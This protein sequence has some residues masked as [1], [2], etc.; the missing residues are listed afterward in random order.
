MS[1][2]IKLVVG[3]E[4]HMPGDLCMKHSRNEAHTGD[5]ACVVEV[6]QGRLGRD[7]SGFFESV[8]G[9]V[10]GEGDFNR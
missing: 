1:V 4:I 3:D 9:H 7:K 10:A 5:V 8:G 6:V 2:V